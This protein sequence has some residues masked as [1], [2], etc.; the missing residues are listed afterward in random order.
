MKFTGERLVPEK[1]KQDLIYGEHIVRYLFAKQFI[2][3]K[4]VLDIASGVGYGTRILAENVKRII[5]VDIS[6]EAIEY[7]KRNYACKNC[8]FLVGDAEKLNFEDKSFDVVV[9]FETIEHLK[10]YK[11]FLEEIRRTLKDNG[12][13]IVSTPNKEIYPPGNPF[14][15]K[16]FSE[17]EFK[18]ELQKLFKFISLEYQNNFINNII[19]KKS[20]YINNLETF[21]DKNINQKPLYIIALCS[22]IPIIKT[23]KRLEFITAPKNIANP[24]IEKELQE[25]TQWAKSLEKEVNERTAWAQKLDKELAER[26]EWAKS[27]EKDI[28]ERT[29]LAQK[30]EKELQERTVWAQELE[31]KLAVFTQL[32][33]KLKNDITDLNKNLSEKNKAIEELNNNISRQKE[34]INNLNAIIGQKDKIILDITNSFSYKLGRFFTFPV[35]ALFPIGSR[36]EVLLHILIKFFLNPIKFS[37]CINIYNIKRFFQAIK[38]ERPDFVL[39]NITNY[40]KINGSKIHATKNENDIAIFQDFKTYKKLVFKREQNPLVSIII[41]VYNQWDYTYSCLFSVLKNTQNVSYEV[42]IADDVSSD[43]TKDINKYIKNINIIRNKK[44]LGFLL[45]C[46]NAAKYAKGKYLLFLNNDTNVQKDWLK[47]LV[48]L[49]EKDEK[50]GMVGSKLIYPDGKLQEAGG[51]IWKD[52]SGWN[53]G[54]LDDPDKPEYNYVKEVD[55]ISGA[56]IMIKKSLWEEIGGF[57]ERYVPAYFEDS[58]LAFEVRKKGYKVM[59]QPKSVVVHFEGISHGKEISEGIKAYQIEN[60]KKFVEKWK[61]VLEKE[62][63]NP[64]ENVFSARDRSGSR[65]TILVIDH[66][67]P[68]FDKDAGSRSTF[69][70]LKLFVEMGLNVKFIGDNFYKHEPYTS[71]LEQIGIEVLYGAWH[72]N[73]W[74]G[75]IKKNAKYIDYIY[76]NRAVISIKY[77]DF[78]KKYTNAKIFFNAADFSYLRLKRQYKITK[79]KKYLNEAEK[80]K[81]QEFY[82]FEKSDVVLTVSEYEK[83]ILKKEMPDKKIYVIPIFIYDKFPLGPDHEFDNRKNITFVGGFRH[84]PNVDGILWFAKEIFPRILE[85]NSSIALNII[86]SDMPEEILKLKSANI[87]VV[88]YVS[89]EKLKDYYS[90]SRLVIAPLRYGAG[91]KGKII[92]AIAYGVPVI[93]TKIG[94]EGIVKANDVLSIADKVD[95]FV[96]K[97]VNIYNDERKWRKIKDAERAYAEN[98]LG[99]NIAKKIFKVILK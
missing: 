37:R 12:L 53:Y 22:N 92:E 60:R 59:Y 26:T 17:K 55:Y 32:T 67:V 28:V 84:E 54:R 39:N 61:D 56:A 64:G 78:I 3:D 29:T 94:A 19:Y 96:K 68:H 24:I 30:L 38:N 89:D 33:E 13:F 62:N 11:K 70:H 73:N 20:L 10:N 85:K 93:T 9:S 25:R 40:L 99:Y 87:N 45:N 72:Q 75:W 66:Y 47:Y 46:N 5:G 71:C 41:P 88:G 16:E 79:D 34:E 86:G 77:I 8:E 31:K 44:N 65:K 6:K 43:K 97:I 14:H 91:V 98:F 51:I 48:D 57:D 95:D 23:Y 1:N 36:R 49:I 82:L 80:Y 4:V 7:A 42:I 27:L 21:R 50:I 90:K 52:G 35:R 63:Y 69:H 18:T 58:D 74:Q 15:I 83:K 76:L 2:K 81:Q